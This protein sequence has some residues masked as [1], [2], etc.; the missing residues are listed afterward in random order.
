MDEK[1]RLLME[2]TGCDRGEAELAL[3]SAGYSLE[4]AIRT[5]PTL[6]RNIVVLKAKFHAPSVHLYGLFMII[7]DTKRKRLFRVK[8]VASYNPS[9][10]EVSLGQD[11][12]DFERRLYGFRL[13]EGA[14]PSVTKDLE[15]LLDDLWS[16]QADVF[17]TLLQSG[18][19]DSILPYLT[20]FLERKLQWTG[21]RLD[22]NREELNLAQFQQLRKEW[23]ET[24]AS[25]PVL[26]RPGEESFPL[27]LSVEVELE[28]DPQGVPAGDVELGDAVFSIISDERDIAK[29]L[30]RLLGSRAGETAIAL[31]TSVE[32][33][34]K[35]ADS[36]KF[37]V[38]LTT[39]IV[40]TAM[41]PIALRVKVQQQQSLNES[42][43]KRFIPWR[44]E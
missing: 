3:T 8:A 38:R 35:Q 23:A 7:L 12:Y 42:W 37:S 6:L 15:I 22:L 32:G 10:Y 30:A 2:E 4:R 39:G 40:G 27:P 28:R 20:E 9:L 25:E 31:P 26:S 33:V 18:E 29:Y 11:W 5:I 16:T 24:S 34:E 21:L 44:R 17:L 13:M 1:I 43:W 41:V 19:M 14:H 36:V